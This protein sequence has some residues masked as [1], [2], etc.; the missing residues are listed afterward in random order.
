VIGVLGAA[1]YLQVTPKV[2]EAGAQI[3]V[4]QIA[5]VNTANSVINFMGINIEEPQALIARMALPTTYPK[6]TIALCGLADI[7]NAQDVLA[8]KVML[9]IPK[10]VTG[11]VDLRIRDHSKDAARACLEAIYQL[12][13]TSQAMIIAPYIDQAAKNLKIDEARLSR[14]TQLIAMAD[15]S[16]A[17]MTAAYLSTLDEIRYLL[18]QISSLRTIIYSGETGYS[19]L[20]APIF[21]NTSP[22]YPKKNVTLITGALLGGFLGLFLALFRSFLKFNPVDSRP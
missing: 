13:K 6:E 11:I 17:T 3:K 7:N 9:S 8:S 2:F 1:L 22:V 19:K 15:K 4:A 12:I 21:V 5:N 16:S 14:A 10:G 20:V 18:N